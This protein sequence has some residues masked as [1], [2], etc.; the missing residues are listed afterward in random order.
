MCGTA[1]R[2]F[3]DHKV[4]QVRDLSCGDT[5]VYLEIEVRRVSRV[6]MAL[7]TDGLLE[8]HEQGG[9]RFYRRRPDVA[10]TRLVGR[11]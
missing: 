6:L 8:V 9:I 3:Y 10:A 7:V 2:T 1:A 4:R 11:P 5:R